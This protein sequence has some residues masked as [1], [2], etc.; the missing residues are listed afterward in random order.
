MIRLPNTRDQSL[1]VRGI[2]AAAAILRE[3][4]MASNHLAQM[5]DL[6]YRAIHR[7]PDLHDFAYQMGWDRILP[8]P[9]AYK[10]ILGDPSVLGIIEGIVVSCIQR[11]EKSPLGLQPLRR[12]FSGGPVGSGIDQIKPSDK[13]SVQIITIPEGAAAEEVPSNKSDLTFHLSLGLGTSG[14]TKSGNE[15]IMGGKIEKTRVQSG[16]TQP[17]PSEEYHR[18]EVIVEDSVRDATDLLKGTLMAEEKMFHILALQKATGS[19]P[20]PT[21]D[22]NKKVHPLTL[23]CL[24]KTDV[25][26]APVNLR[27][28]PR[29]GLE[30]DT[31][32][33]SPALLPQGPQELFHRLIAAMI[34]QSRDPLIEY[35]TAQDPREE[36]LY[37]HILVW[38][39]YSWT[40]TSG[41]VTRNVSALKISSNCLAS[42][43]SLSGNLA[44]THPLASHK[45]NI[46][47]FLLPD[48]DYLLCLHNVR[49]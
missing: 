38:I 10:T 44:D 39:Q 49:R 6:D 29:I 34:S 31:G 37:Q 27:L 28:F 3:V 19:K 32:F 16:I 36:K 33:S 26:M 24:L 15:A 45:L 21:K 9:P 46:H 23:A 43:T 5:E 41:L 35:N 18:F 12:N 22:Q 42:M 7:L 47:P 2:D 17:Q 1:E 8:S 30:T 20:A 25:E 40:W 4:P 14:W 13:L 11:H 48:H